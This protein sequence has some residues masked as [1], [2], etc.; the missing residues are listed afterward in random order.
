MEIEHSKTFEEWAK[1][2]P[3]KKALSEPPQGS[4]GDK[5]NPFD[6]YAEADSVKDYIETVDEHGGML[7]VEWQGKFYV[8]YDDGYLGGFADYES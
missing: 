4:W 5:Y 1:S 3:A 2:Y 6:T 8:V 7:V